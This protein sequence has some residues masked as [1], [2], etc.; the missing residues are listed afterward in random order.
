M[1]SVS[2]EV[3]G[4]RH[5]DPTLVPTAWEELATFYRYEGAQIPIGLFGSAV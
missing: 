2:S 1:L 5:V 3:F 4:H